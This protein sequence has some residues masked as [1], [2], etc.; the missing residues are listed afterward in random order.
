MD[1]QEWDLLIDAEDKKGRASLKNIWQYRDLLLLL[2]RRDFVSFYKQTILGPIWF[3][4]KPVFATIVYFFIFSKVAGLSTD[5]I[6]PILFYISGLSL[7]SFFT[8]TVTMCSGVLVTNSNIFSKV[9]FPRLI[10]P[11]SIVFSNL[12][13]LG[14]QFSLMILLIAYYYLNTV[15][16]TA[17]LN[18]LLIP[19]VIIII[20]FQAAGI[21]LL[22]ASIGVK[23][24]DISMLISYALQLGLFISPVIFP[25]S[26]LSGN[27]R[28]LLLVN[29]M[30]LPIELFRFSLFGTG[31]FSVLSIVYMI[32]ITLVIIYLGIRAF[33]IFE[34][35]F[36]DTI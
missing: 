5:A 6:P 17:S 2:V 31:T 24:R 16:L 35:T 29:P 33:N 13:K 34:K 22:V 14:V 3:F 19:F 18:I 4:I 32:S 28:L 23:Y 1:G 9:Y 8:D 20:S 11:L 7:W 36:V 27:L 10:M 30:T 12:L 25:L 26:S 15:I 21:G